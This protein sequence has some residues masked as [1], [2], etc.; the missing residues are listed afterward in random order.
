M[1][2]QS[3]DGQVEGE[4]GKRGCTGRHRDEGRNKARGEIERERL[5]PGPVPESCNRFEFL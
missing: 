2:V 1:V 3:T 5:I 4:R